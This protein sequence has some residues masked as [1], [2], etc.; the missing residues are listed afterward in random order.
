MAKGQFRKGNQSTEGSFQQPNGW[1]SAFCGQCANPF[2]KFSSKCNP[3]DQ[4][5]VEA[6]LKIEVRQTSDNSS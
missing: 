6:E 3:S 2:E 4:K 1:K 5:R